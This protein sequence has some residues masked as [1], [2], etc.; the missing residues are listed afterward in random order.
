MSFMPFKL[1][2]FCKN[3]EKTNKIKKV[4]LQKKNQFSIKRSEIRKT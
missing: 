3:M 1:L 2:L 4:E